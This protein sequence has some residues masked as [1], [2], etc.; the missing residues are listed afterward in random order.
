MA[1]T[2]KRCADCGLEKP[3][4]ADHFPVRRGGKSVERGY[5][6]KRCKPCH[7]VNQ[8][9]WRAAHPGYD[10][11]CA[12]HKRQR[13]VLA[14]RLLARAAT[15]LGDAPLA[16]ELR[17]FIASIPKRHGPTPAP[18]APV[19]A[20]PPAQP[21]DASRAAAIALFEANK[22]LALSIV[23][24]KF[25]G[26]L[27]QSIGL[28]IEDFDQMA[29]AG[30]WHAAQ[31]FDS[32]RGLKFSSY[33]WQCI[34]GFVMT[35]LNHFRFGRRNSPEA[36]RHNHMDCRKHLQVVDAN[37]WAAIEGIAKT[38]RHDV[39]DAAVRNET[40]EAVNRA[41]D[42][43]AKESWRKVIRIRMA[44]GTLQQ[45][46]EAIGRTKARAQQIERKAKELLARLLRDLEAA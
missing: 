20:A 40:V 43:M 11:A 33:A 3:L 37:G 18:A 2:V 15:A 6:L 38:G 34:A 45:A 16:G 21:V 5:F 32:T 19:C 39:T 24:R 42:S 9:A 14:N 41:I 4:D 23:R 7:A 35:G 26:L 1:A 22:P 13:W 28:Q 29:L 46:S 27:A 8:A 31:R 30:L 25:G 12:A 36:Q 10:N 44:G 17:A